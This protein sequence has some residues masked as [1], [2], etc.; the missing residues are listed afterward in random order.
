MTSVAVSP[1]S[2][3]ARLDAPLS[4]WLWLLKRLLVLPHH[5]NSKIDH[6][7]RP[8]IRI[9]KNATMLSTAKAIHR[10]P[11]NRAAGASAHI[12]TS[13]GTSAAPTGV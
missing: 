11:S 10:N 2:V 1:V 7:Y 3:N 4:R 9:A 5:V 8:V 12:P 13:N 6:G